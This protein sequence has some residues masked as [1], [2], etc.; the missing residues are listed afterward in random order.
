MKR[1]ALAAVLAC[2]FSVTTLAGDIPS[3]DFFS[4]P[5]PSQ[6]PQEQTAPPN[7][8]VLTDNTEDPMDMLIITILELVVR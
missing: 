4:P 2:A 5:P 7:A 8:T 1:F 3:G 6:S